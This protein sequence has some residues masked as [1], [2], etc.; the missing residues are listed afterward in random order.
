M[1]KKTNKQTKQNKTKNKTKQNKTL[2]KGLGILT[3]ENRKIENLQIQ[4]LIIDLHIAFSY[5]PSSAS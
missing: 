2:R 1:K 5:P 4:Y 3:L